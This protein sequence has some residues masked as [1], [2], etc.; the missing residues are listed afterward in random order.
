MQYSYEKMIGLYYEVV[1][2][3]AMEVTPTE[4]ERKMLEGLLESKNTGDLG[5]WVDSFPRSVSP[6]PSGVEIF[7]DR[8]MGLSPI[9]LKDFS[10]R[11]LAEEEAY[12][13]QQ[14]EFDEPLESVAQKLYSSI[15]SH[16]IANN[17]SLQPAI[18]RQHSVFCPGRRPQ[19][20]PDGIRRR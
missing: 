12:E 20:S 11:L 17:S 4:K 1:Q 13:I 16:S 7:H 14:D 6:R 9:E 19:V 5:K 18:F 2:R 15:I 3:Y 8:L 10:G